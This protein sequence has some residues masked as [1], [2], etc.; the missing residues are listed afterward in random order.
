MLT[1]YWRGTS[2]QGADQRPR[3]VRPGKER[4]EAV[5]CGRLGEELGRG[6]Q[7]GSLAFFI[8]ILF[9]LFFFFH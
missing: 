2:P 5:L 7:P 8:F 4:G 9:Y 1:I 6:R 3:E